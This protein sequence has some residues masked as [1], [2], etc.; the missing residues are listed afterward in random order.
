MDLLKA[1]QGDRN[2]LYEKTMKRE[3]GGPNQVTTE[4]QEVTHACGGAPHGQ[5]RVVK[6]A[7]SVVGHFSLENI[8][9]LG[10]VRCGEYADIIVK[11]SDY[12]FDV[13]SSI[14]PK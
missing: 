2:R 14:T 13:I 9:V 4:H 11:G 12:C 1:L 8:N 7:L 5:I 10:I 6:Q 3:S